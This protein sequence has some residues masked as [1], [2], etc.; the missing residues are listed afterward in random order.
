M[1]NDMV[2]HQEKDR[3]D[4]RRLNQLQRFPSWAVDP[5]LLF[6][7]LKSASSCSLKVIKG[8]SSL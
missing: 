5:C 8:V 3:G 1:L 6:G 2:E 4:E 7:S